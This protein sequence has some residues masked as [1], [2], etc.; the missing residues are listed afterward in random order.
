MGRN[1]NVQRTTPWREQSNELPLRFATWNVRSMLNAEG[2][3]E[4]AA[5]SKLVAEDR[6]VDLVVHQLGRF[7]IEAAGLQETK[8][9]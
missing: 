7:G 4:T 5:T 1:G 8:W 9:F 2:P 6:K 3:I